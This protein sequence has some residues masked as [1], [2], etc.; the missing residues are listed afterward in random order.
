MGNWVSIRGEFGSNLPSPRQ[1]LFWRVTIESF[2]GLHEW[3]DAPLTLL[4][5]G[6]LP[7]PLDTSWRAQQVRG[8]IA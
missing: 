2:W 7:R 6:S 4:Q 8:P 3:R 1:N 5:L